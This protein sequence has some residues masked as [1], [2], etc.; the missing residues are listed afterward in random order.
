METDYKNKTYTIDG[1]KYKYDKDA[2][3][4]EGPETSKYYYYQ[5]VIRVGTSDEYQLTF[6]ITD[7]YRIDE[8]RYAELLQLQNNEGVSSEESDE[9]ITLEGGLLE[10][11]ACDWN[12][13]SAIELV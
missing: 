10:E 13:I 12:C 3:R 1:I 7:Q 6:D 8:L 4:A 11:Y 9:L 2:F 5:F